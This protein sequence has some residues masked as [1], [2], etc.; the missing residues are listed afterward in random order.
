MKKLTKILI[1]LMLCV[2]SIGFVACD[3]RTEKEKNFTYPAAADA[4]KGNGGMAV[5]K[6][7]YL[8]FVNGYKSITTEGLNKKS[9]FN[10]GSLMLM[11]LD[12][13]GNIVTD[14]KGLLKDEY[15]ISMHNKLCGYEATNLYIHGEYLYFATPTMEDESKETAG[16]K[17]VWAK[18]RTLICRIKL[19]K[20]SKVETVYE[21]GVKVENLEYEYYEEGGNLFILV[22]EKGNSYYADNGNN[23]LIRVH[24]NGKSSSLVATDVTDVVFAENTDEI[25]YLQDKE[26]KQYNIATAG[27]TD[28]ATLTNS[29]DLQF[30]ANGELYATESVSAGDNSGTKLK[31]SNIANKSGFSDVYTYTES[32]TLSVTPDGLCVVGAGQDK[33]VLIR[34]G[35]APIFIN[36]EGASQVEVSGFVNGCVIYVVDKDE[37]HVIQSISYSNAVAGDTQTP[38][39]LATLTLDVRKFDMASDENYLY[40]LSK[41][42]S[43]N[44]LTRVK[45]RQ[46][47]EEKFEVV[48]VYENADIPAAEETPA[49]DEE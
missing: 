8:Y 27:Y 15:Y 33:L 44:Y 18:E 9:T 28:Y 38:R 17:D 13:D 30:V 3:K 14:E 26:L 19:D 46:N 31:V 2:L 21:C 41:Q 7:N 10:V 23:A 34:A 42:G 22:Y 35:H 47:I 43:N 45:V 4:I 12:E 39:T 20:T 49:E 24:A 37:K 25:F 29:L 32:L 36:V 1:C 5:Q 6:G 40:L 11:K 16:D 48:G